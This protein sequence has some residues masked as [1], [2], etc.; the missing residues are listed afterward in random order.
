MR[1]STFR[2]GLGM[3]TLVVLVGCASGSE[4]ASISLD[5]ASSLS[6][7][8]GDT[9][10]AAVTLTRSHFDQAIHLSVTGG[11][12]GVSANILPATIT[13]SLSSAVLTVV[14][15]GAATPGT[16]HFTV[17]ATG[18]GVAAQTANVDVS[19]SVTGSYTLSTDAPVRVAQT[20]GS[21]TTI[22]VNRVGGHADSV[23]LSVTGAPAGMVAVAQPAATASGDAWLDVSAGANVA[24]GLYT[25]TIHGTANDLADQTTSVKVRVIA[26]P[27]TAPLTIAFC[28][29]AEPSWLA[30]QNDGYRWSVA[31]PTNSSFTFDATQ[32]VGVAFAFT[33]PGF[34][35]TNVFFAGRDELAAINTLDC[36]GPLNVSGNTAGLV[37]SQIA[38]AA[39]ANTLAQATTTA[40]DYIMADI[41]DRPLDLVGTSGLPVGA[42]FVP[43]KMIIYRGLAPAD[44]DSLPTLDFSGPDA[45]DLLTSTLTISGMSGLEATQEQTTLWTTTATYGLVQADDSPPASM[46][47]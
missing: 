16:A 42:G 18:D 5:V 44:G 15:S 35:Q 39:F 10:T 45:F 25:L 34:V 6:L 31:T 1:V 22:I 7:G 19:V 13:G 33:E 11:A 20:G 17:H 40:S 2:S 36:P 47:L 26:P 27:N 23:H 46:T 38:L 8:Q 14:A 43:D 4:P 12:A 21:G 9:N 29:G 41:Q 3:V 32:K 24:P 37:T 30:Y 28:A